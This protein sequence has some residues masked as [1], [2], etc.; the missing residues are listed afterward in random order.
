MRSAEDVE[1]VRLSARPVER[2][3]QPLV[4][5]LAR[6]VLG[7]ESLELG[8]EVCM[9]PRPELRV[10]SEL[11][12]PETLL[13][14]L[15][16]EV[17]HPRFAAQVGQGAAAPQREGRSDA[18]GRHGRIFGE[19]RPRLGDQPP[20]ALEVELAG[21][22]AQLVA[23][24]ASAHTGRVAEHLAEPGDVHRNRVL[25]GPRRILGPQ[26][27]DQPRDRNGL[28]RADHEVGEERA[29]LR[30]P[31]HDGNVRDPRLEWPE[32]PESE[33]HAQPSSAYTT[34]ASGPS[35][36]PSANTSPAPSSPSSARTVA[37]VSSKRAAR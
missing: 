4:E 25:R 14:E 5:T 27:V 31:Q 1:R 32:H 3:H 13:L 12:G 35:P 21:C 24:G 34:A 36:R 26:L 37:C 8:Y 11:G 22:E 18:V 20:E 15:E 28:V 29:L 7:E 10:E 9:P 6:R 33:R 30:R 19:P 23:A 16:H 2:E 17:A